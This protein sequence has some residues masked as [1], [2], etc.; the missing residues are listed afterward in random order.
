MVRGDI[1]L[2]VLVSKTEIDSIV[3]KL[4]ARIA[5]DYGPV[6]DAGD[7]LVLV[8]V[9]NGAI[10]FGVDLSRAIQLPLEIEPVKVES[11]KGDEAVDMNMALDLRRDVGPSDHLLVVEDIVDTGM[12]AAMLLDRF[13]KTE[14]A[15]VRFCSLLDKPTRRISPVEVDYIG[16]TV[17]DTFV[18]GYGLDFNGEYR[19]LP[20]VAKGVMS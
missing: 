15:S 12:T 4:G 18:V 3:G 6:V 8:P 9:L 14:A 11:Y 2:S 13:K 20:Y 10:Y 17:P 16:A 7:S 19:N 1:D 5:A